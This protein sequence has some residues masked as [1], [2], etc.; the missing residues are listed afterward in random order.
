MMQNPMMQQ[1]MNN[2]R[3]NPA[4]LQ[5]MIQSNPMLQQMSQQ[6]PMMA[7]MMSNPA[8]LQGAMQMMQNPQ[9]MQML[10]NPQMMQALGGTPGAMRGLPAP[11]ATPPAEDAGALAPAN[12]MAAMMQDPAMMQAMI[13][14]MGGLPPP[15]ATPPV[16]GADAPAVPLSAGMSAPAANPMAAMMQDPGMMQAMM[17][18][19]GG[20]G[21]PGA[22]AGASN[23]MGGMD[24][25]MIGQ[26]M[27]NP[28]MQQMMN[29]M[30]QNPAMLQ[31]MMQALGGTPGAMRGLPAPTATH[32]AGDAG[33]PA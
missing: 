22:G 33:A 24:P 12:P 25:A 23:P 18:M 9:M 27:Q 5:Q 26:M 1:M 29:N 10:Q 13:G 6:N 4:M 28:V 19:M 15:I 8:V 31:Q 16:G 2:M 11:T 32:P 21:M 20:A 3:Q 14:M 30:F 17:G 7:Q